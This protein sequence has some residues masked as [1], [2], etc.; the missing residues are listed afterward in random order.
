MKSQDCRRLVYFS[1]DMVYG[2]SK[3]VPVDTGQP[4][5][6]IGPY[7]ASK[8]DS[9]VLCD[10][11]RKG[12]MRITVLRPRM[13]MGPGRLGV[14]LK[15]FKLISKGLPVPMIGSG[16]NHYQM[17]SV[18]DCVSA[19]RLADKAG[20]PNEVYNLGSDR[21]PRVKELLGHLIRHASSRSILLPTPGRVMKATLAILDR[22]GMGLMYPEQFLIADL[23]C[24]VDIEA[25]KKGLN[26]APHFDDRAM[27]VQAYDEYCKMSPSKTQAAANP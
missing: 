4:L 9:E 19:A 2:I 5:H 1:S 13:I 20:I 17:V 7:G 23:D 11:F 8:R 18:F 22:V 25:T 24:R 3:S 14:L 26:W 16:T 12:G 21:P 10:S 15:L 6:P 27:I